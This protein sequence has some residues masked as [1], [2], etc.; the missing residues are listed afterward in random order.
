MILWGA[1]PKEA[2]KDAKNRDSMADHTQASG[3]HYSKD[4][5]L[6][7]QGHAV[8]G[9]FPQ[10]AIRPDYLGSSSYKTCPPTGKFVVNF[11]DRLGWVCRMGIVVLWTERQSL[12]PSHLRACG[13][14]QSTL[15]RT[16]RLATYLRGLTPTTPGR[17]QGRRD[18]KINGYGP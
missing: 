11:D 16:D 7:R 8:A 5:H 4:T 17:R 13:T 3:L 10:Q 18:G 14:V 1:L 9:V 2:G 6:T 15:Q 12:N